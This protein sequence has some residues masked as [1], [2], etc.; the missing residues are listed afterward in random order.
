MPLVGAGIGWF[1]NFLAIRMIFNPKKPVSVLGLKI[2]GLLPKRRT[3]LAR[4]VAETVESE[5]VSHHDIRQAITD[6]EFL[7]SLKRRVGKQLR[8]F[9]EENVRG[10][11]WLVRA[12]V[13]RDTID[14][15]CDGIVERVTGFLPQMLF[16]TAEV[17][18]ERLNFRELVFSKI[19]NFDVDKLEEVVYRIAKRELKHIEYLGAVLGFIIGAVEVGI[20]QFLL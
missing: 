19:E 3:E 5:L 1:T 13:S 9:L 15:V 11:S 8:G 16:E 17:L 2:L 20:V 14:R 7:D 4:S 10:A 12:M 18:E 6:P